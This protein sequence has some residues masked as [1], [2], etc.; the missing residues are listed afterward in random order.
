MI[1]IIQRLSMI[2]QD[3]VTTSYQQVTIYLRFL[4]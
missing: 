3:M 2:D 4:D 1:Q